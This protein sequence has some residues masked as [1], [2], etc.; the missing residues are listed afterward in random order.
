[1]KRKTYKNT[2]GNIYKVKIKPTRKTMDKSLIAKRQAL[3]QALVKTQATQA[4][5]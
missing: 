3:A 1:M 5:A 2:H 4:K